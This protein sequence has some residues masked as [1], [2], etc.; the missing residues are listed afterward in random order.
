M[1]HSVADPGVYKWGGGGGGGLINGSAML[2][3]IR[4]VHGAAA[5]G[6]LAGHR[7]WVWEGDVPHSA[8][9]G[10]LWHF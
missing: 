1:I 7:G 5:Y 3:G 10:S 4:I 2:C 9:G 8:E 6:Q